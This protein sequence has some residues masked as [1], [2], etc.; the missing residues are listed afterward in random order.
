MKP[1]LA[2]SASGFL[3]PERGWLA[4]RAALLIALSGCGTASGADTTV[5][6]RDSSDVRIVDN[7]GTPAL[8]DLGWQV[9][10][11]PMLEIG[12]SGGAA[13]GLFKVTEAVRLEDGRIVVVNAGSNDLRI[14]GPDGQH[15]RTIG[16]EGDGPGEFRSL[17][18]AGRLRGDSIVAWDAAL[19][20][21]SVFS[22]A[23]DLVRSVRPARSLGFFPQVKGLLSDGRVVMASSAAPARISE[24]RVQVRRDSSAF[25]ILAPHGGV[26]EI[27]GRFL[28]TEMVT[29][30][31]PAAGLLVR[32]LP[33]GRQTVTATHGARLYVG[34]ADRFEIAAYEPATSLRMLVRADRER[35]PVTREDIRAYRQTLVTVGADAQVERHQAKVLEQVPYPKVMPAF[36][37]LEVDSDGNLWVEEPQKPGDTAGSTWVVLS[38][39]GRARGTIRLPHGLAVKQIGRDWILGVVLDEDHREIVRLYQF[40][41][42]GGGRGTP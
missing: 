16:R 35:A 7:R 1:S 8:R 15:L 33:F 12:S 6:V 39:D 42:T 19:Q 36:S 29:I 17:F 34:T 40:S 38:S 41:R 32:P 3:R 18:W 28:G 27:R 14:F 22:P 20:R 30:A 21:L 5:A 11:Q 23:G 2:S 13:S 10:R 37:G 25:R 31:D 4:L 24:S 9:D 26:S